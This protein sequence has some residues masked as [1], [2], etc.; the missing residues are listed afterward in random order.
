M[1]KKNLTFNHVL[2]ESSWVDG[3]SIHTI[4][5]SAMLKSEDNLSLEGRLRGP[6]LAWWEEITKLGLKDGTFPGEAFDC[7]WHNSILNSRTEP[8]SIIYRSVAIFVA[9]ESYYRH[10]WNQ[11]CRNLREISLMRAVANVLGI[12]M[13]YNSII[14]ALNCN[15]DILEGIDGVRSVG[16]KRFSKLFMLFIRLFIPFSVSTYKKNIIR[17]LKK[18]YNIL[19]ILFSRIFRRANRMINVR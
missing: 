3:V 9:K 4:L 12:K 10:R 7:I 6:L 15:L 18:I 16:F 1:G 5:S 13:T 19:C 17:E 11:S 14:K 8:M 2:C